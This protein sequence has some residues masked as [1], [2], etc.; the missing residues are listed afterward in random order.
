MDIVQ[1]Q[2]IVEESFPAL[3][4]Q[5]AGI[6]HASKENGRP[7]LRIGRSVKIS[8]RLGQLQLGKGLILSIESLHDGVTCNAPHQFRKHRCVNGRTYTYLGR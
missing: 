2:S 7:V 5:E 6:Y 1:S 8:Q 3:L 4:A